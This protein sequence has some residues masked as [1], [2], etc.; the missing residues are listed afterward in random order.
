M[1]D[2]THRRAARNPYSQAAHNKSLAVYLATH[3]QPVPSS[4]KRPAQVEDRPSRSDKRQRRE[5]EQTLEV[6][7]PS[8]AVVLKFSVVI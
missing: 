2:S 3:N 1:S 8:V 4:L 7:F 6:C 5:H